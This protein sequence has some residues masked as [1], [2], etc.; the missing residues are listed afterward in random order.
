MRGGHIFYGDELLLEDKLTSST[1]DFLYACNK[2]SERGIILDR[3][4]TER[5][6]RLAYPEHEQL[7]YSVKEMPSVWTMIIDASIQLDRVSEDREE[8]H[9]DRRY[10]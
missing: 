2:I 3:A 7:P 1:N 9:Y 4:A 5:L 6:Y 8:E 10:Y